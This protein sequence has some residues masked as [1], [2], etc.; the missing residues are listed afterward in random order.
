MGSVITTA[1][2]L[3]VITPNVSDTTP[4][5]GQS[6]TVNATVKNQGDGA[7][8]GTTLRYYRSTDATISSTDT[9]LGTDPVSGLSPNNS[10]PESLSTTAPN[11]PGTYWI[12]ACVDSVS[13]E[14]STGNNCSAGVQ[15]T[16]SS[17]ITTAPDLVVIT[18]GVSN[19]T[20]TPGQS[21]TI[22]ATVKNQGD[23]ASGGTTLRYYR[24]TDAAISSTDTSLG[25]DPVSGLSPNN[26]SP[27]SLSTT[28]PNNPGTYW[29]GACVDSVSGESSTGNNCSAGVEIVVSTNPPAQSNS[30]VGVFRNGTW[31]LDNGNFTWDG[32]GSFPNDDLCLVNSFGAPGDLPV[33]GDWTGTGESAVGVFRNGTWFLDN[34]NFIWDGCGAFPDND[35]CLIN[36][37]GAPGDLPVAGDWGQ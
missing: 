30:S 11:N 3:V 19:A 4:T 21:F 20:P 32:C 1:P 14:S 28:A 29:I 2:D 35:L 16:V 26:S 25:T 5:P 18:P 33:A 12:G 22:T 15:I 7:S 9:S 36:T 23:G 24:S 8:G 37:F 31:F 6:F 10:S 34:G 27:E 17:I 13:G